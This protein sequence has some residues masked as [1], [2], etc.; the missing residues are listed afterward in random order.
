MPILFNLLAPG[1]GL[2]VLGR[3]WV[4]LALAG[5]FLAGAEMALLG[6][7]IAPAMLPRS[8]S[9]AAAATA[10]GVWLLAQALLLGRLRFLRSAELPRE[11]AILQRLARRALSRSD[12][13]AAR[14]AVA[15]ALSLDDSDLTSHVLHARLLSLSGRTAKARRAWLRVRRM[16]VDRLHAHEVASRLDDVPAS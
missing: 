13:P 14:A 5:T 2:L 3:P 15:L 8:I 10:G 11:L 12:L 16:D 6:L 7:L 9:V 4:G 1:T